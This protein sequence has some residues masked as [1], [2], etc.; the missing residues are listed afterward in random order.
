V[1]FPLVAP[2]GAEA[3]IWERFALDT[4]GFVPSAGG[5]ELTR[6]RA[7]LRAR[8]GSI[9][10]LNNAH[11]TARAS[12]EDVPLPHDLPNVPKLR[13]DW[14]QFVRAPTVHP[15]RRAWPGFLARRYQIPKALGAAYG[16]SWTEFD[17]VPLPAEL[18]PDGAALV[19]WFQYEGIVLAMTRTAHRFTVVLPVPPGQSVSQAD[20]QRR[21]DLAARVVAMEKPAHTVFDIRFYWAMFRLGEARLGIDTAIDRNSRALGLTRPMVLGQGHLAESD[22]TARIP[23][24]LTAGRFL[25]TAP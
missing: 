14:Q 16:T 12:F 1:D 17:L 13:M 4:L 5:A 8:Y 20:Q 11:G 19:D 21:L 10:E 7:F 6:W 18:P 3:G 23:S 9:V 2:T 24:E 15:E 22:L 25:G